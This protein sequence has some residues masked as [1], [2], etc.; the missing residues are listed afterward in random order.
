MFTLCKIL[1]D[2]NYATCSESEIATFSAFL[3]KT[4]LLITKNK[5]LYPNLTC[6]IKASQLTV[7]TVD[8]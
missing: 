5:G 3:S 6:R 2:L 1:Q 7:D 8:V 4:S